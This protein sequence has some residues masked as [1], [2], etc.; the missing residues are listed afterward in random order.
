[1]KIYGE[2]QNQVDVGPNWHQKTN[3][4]DFI[5]IGWNILGNKVNLENRKDNV[6][7]HCRVLAMSN[8]T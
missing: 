4:L 6:S 5:S 2:R 7:G 1:M 3:F 8:F